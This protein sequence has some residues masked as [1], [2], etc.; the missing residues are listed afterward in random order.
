MVFENFGNAIRVCTECIMFH[1]TKGQSH[2]DTA[3]GCSEVSDDRKRFCR[4]VA[5]VGVRSVR[6]HG[7]DE[8]AGTLTQSQSPLAYVWPLLKPRAA[9]CWFC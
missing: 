9:C 6:G 2:L 8:H 3:A 1:P 5:C 7:G 4:L